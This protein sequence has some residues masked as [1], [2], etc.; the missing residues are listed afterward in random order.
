MTKT[1]E[2]RIFEETYPAKKIGENP[3]IAIE[4]V[5]YLKHLKV[6]N[7]EQAVWIDTFISALLLGSTLELLEM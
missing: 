1:K 6:T 2:R 5:G 3:I 7:P 4:A